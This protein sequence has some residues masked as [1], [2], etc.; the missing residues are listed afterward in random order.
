MD[1]KQRYQQVV[2]H[3]HKAISME[4]A[5]RRESYLFI[6]ISNPPKEKWVYLFLLKPSED[7]TFSVGDVTELLLLFVFDQT[8]G[9]AHAQ[10]SGGVCTS[11]LGSKPSTGL[12]K[13]NYVALLLEI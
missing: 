7:G 1:V 13:E 3:V 4:V 10:R 2:P 12:Q 9:S 6:Q 11:H 8:I 5:G